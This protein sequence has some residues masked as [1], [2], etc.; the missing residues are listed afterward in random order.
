MYYIQVP[1]TSLHCIITCFI[2][3]QQTQ[4]TIEKQDNKHWNTKKKEKTDEK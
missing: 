2:I 3:D 1:P 4:N